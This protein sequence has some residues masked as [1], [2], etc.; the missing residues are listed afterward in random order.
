MPHILAQPAEAVAPR[1][2]R[3]LSHPGGRNEE[4]IACGHAFF[5]KML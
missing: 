5:L 1:L 4:V 3:I 2:R